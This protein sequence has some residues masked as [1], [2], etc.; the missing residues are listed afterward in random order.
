MRPFGSLGGHPNLQI[1][2]T[3]RIEFREQDLPIASENFTTKQQQRLASTTTTTLSHCSVVQEAQN[4]KPATFVQDVCRLTTKR[5]A[6][7]SQQ[8]WNTST[9]FCAMRQ[10]HEDDTYSKKVNTATPAT[11]IFHI[12][13]EGKMHCEVPDGQ[14]ATS[15]FYLLSY[16]PHHQKLP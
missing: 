2:R 5:Y 14:F 1:C 10:S 3:I 7:S 12:H 11:R 13:A 8:C 16:E 9:H 4:D 15:E 6:E